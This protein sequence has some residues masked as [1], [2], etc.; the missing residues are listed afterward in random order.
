MYKI[1]ENN[2]LLADL[3]YVT[4]QVDRLKAEDC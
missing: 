1:R 4:T 2:I 3:I